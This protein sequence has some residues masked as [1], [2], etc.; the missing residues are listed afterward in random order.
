MHL[1]KIKLLA[2]SWLR[3]FYGSLA[4]WS[5]F[6]QGALRNFHIVDWL[7]NWMA[8]C[9][10]KL[11]RKWQTFPRPPDKTLISGSFPFFCTTISGSRTAATR[12]AIINYHFNLHLGQSPTCNLPPI[13]CTESALS[14][15]FYYYASAANQAKRK[16][17][18]FYTIFLYFLVC[19]PE[20]R[21][22]VM[23]KL[24]ENA[25]ET[26]KLCR[27]KSLD[28]DTNTKWS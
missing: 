20:K 25:K 19:S 14:V 1:A 8:G 17:L 6:L 12:M 23:W 24:P 10:A 3:R 26:K 2:Q 4:L 16:L 22:L 9:P 13:I 28:L 15:L 21:S 5:P 7:T 27:Q 11:P 18:L